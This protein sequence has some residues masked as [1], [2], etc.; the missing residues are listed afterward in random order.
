MSG[1]EV[2]SAVHE[3]LEHID[4]AAPVVPEIEDERVR[5]ARHAYVDSPLAQRLGSLAG[6]TK[7]RHFT[8]EHD[9]VLVHGF[10]D[11]LQLADGKA[12]VV[13]YKTN[14]IGES[15]PEEIVEEDYRLQRLVYALACFR[16]G[17]EEVEVVYTFLERPNEPVEARF[18]L[19]DLP[20]LEEELS[21][22][23]ARHPG[24]RVPADAERVRVRRLPGSRPRLRWSAPSQRAE[25]LARPCLAQPSLDEESCHIHRHPDGRPEHEYGQRARRRRTSSAA[26]RM[27]S[28]LR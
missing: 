14:L 12:L 15:S 17:A 2:G 7:E 21:A 26:G 4:L 9:G 20:A 18:T 13:D 1:V 23:I 3:L 28:W 25:R 19:A 10:L 11:V 27:V 6:V 16:A 24:R 5:D 22:A 8:F